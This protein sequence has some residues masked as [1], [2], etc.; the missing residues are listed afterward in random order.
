[1][2]GMGFETSKRPKNF[3]EEAQEVIDQFLGSEDE[4]IGRTFETEEEAAAFQRKMSAVVRAYC[5]EAAKTVR[6]GR[7]VYVVKTNG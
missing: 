5:T 4:C 7:T 6:S 2:Y 1:M 3:S